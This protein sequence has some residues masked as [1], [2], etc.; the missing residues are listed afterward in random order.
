MHPRLKSI[1]YLRVGQW[2][3]IDPTQSSTEIQIK[4]LPLQKFNKAFFKF[5]KTQLRPLQIC[6]YSG[7]TIKLFFKFPD[8]FDPSCMIL[9]N[10]VGKI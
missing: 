8:N 1:E 3:S 4:F 9:M 5:T 6:N 10:S 7:W 2:H